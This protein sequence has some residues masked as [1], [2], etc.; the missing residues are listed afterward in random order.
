M[1]PIR[2]VL[3]GPIFLLTELKGCDIIAPPFKMA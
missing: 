3:A 2:R 1:G